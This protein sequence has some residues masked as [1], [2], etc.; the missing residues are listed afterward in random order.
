MISTH[1]LKQTIRAENILARRGFIYVNGTRFDAIALNRLLQI[2]SYNRHSKLDLLLN[3][4]VS[5][6][7]RVVAS[8]KI[9]KKIREVVL[10]PIP[11][12]R[13][14]RNHLE[15]GQFV[16]DK[17][18][19]IFC[20]PFS[21]GNDA[22]AEIIIFNYS[23]VDR[24]ARFANLQRLEIDLCELGLDYVIEQFSPLSLLEPDA[25]KKLCFD[26]DELAKY[27]KS[28]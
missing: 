28:L 9:L 16:S 22:L 13:L 12:N 4:P 18:C 10:K 7:S 25:L 2:K 15:W 17:P 14:G 26:R 27:W 20:D 11:K 24:I 6:A 1:S 21:G 8:P 5:W 3:K 23:I 19:P